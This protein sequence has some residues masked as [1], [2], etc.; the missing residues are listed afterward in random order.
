MWGI[1]ALASSNG[2]S[3][4]MCLC[5]TTRRTFWP[6]RGVPLEVAGCVPKS[7]SPAPPHLC[8]ATTWLFFKETLPSTL[9]DSTPLT[10]CRAQFHTDDAPTSVLW[11]P[12]PVHLQWL[13]P[14][15]CLSHSFPWRCHWTCISGCKPFIITILNSLLSGQWQLFV[16]FFQLIFYAPL[17]IIPQLHKYLQS[18][19]LITFSLFLLISSLYLT[20]TKFFH[21]YCFFTI[22]LDNTAVFIP[23][24][25]M[26]KLR[27]V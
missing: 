21:I 6:D 10:L 23:I 18:I 4:S 20:S 25:W 22:S 19:S 13:G 16:C 17:P 11:I 9:S 12:C 26:K 14:P 7:S 3:L 5:G 1:R 8:P 27:Y 2:P 15:L 24:V